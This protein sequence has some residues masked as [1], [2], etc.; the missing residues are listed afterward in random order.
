MVHILLEL[1]III[2][3]FRIGAIVGDFPNPLLMSNYKYEYNGQYPKTVYIII[4]N[5]G[6]YIYL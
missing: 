5:S 1:G 2:I 4:N 3:I 6:G